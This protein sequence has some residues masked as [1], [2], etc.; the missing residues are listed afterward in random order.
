M[1][2]HFYKYGGLWYCVNPE[3]IAG[4]GYTP[5]HAHTDYMQVNGLWVIA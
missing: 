4:L 3:M 5:E 1:K 2:L